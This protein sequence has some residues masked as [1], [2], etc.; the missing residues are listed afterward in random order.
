MTIRNFGL[1]RDQKSGQW[2]EFSSIDMDEFFLKTMPE[3]YIE[4][5]MFDTLDK[6]C[7]LMSNKRSINTH[8]L[9]R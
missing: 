8:K 5:C 7:E 6:G 2:D 1:T 3:I 4:H 9:V